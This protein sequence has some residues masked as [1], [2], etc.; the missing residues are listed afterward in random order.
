MKRKLP[1]EKQAKLYKKLRKKGFSIKI[2][3]NLMKKPALA[4]RILLLNKRK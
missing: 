4:R 2:A 1:T 3:D